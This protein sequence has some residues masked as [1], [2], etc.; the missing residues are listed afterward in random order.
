MHQLLNIVL[1]DGKRHRLHVVI[2]AGHVNVGDTLRIF[3]DLKRRL[4]Q[5]HGIDLL[6][7]IVIAKKRERAPLM[8]A[9]FLAS[10]YSMMRASSARGGIDYAAET[11][12]PPKGQAGL[13]FLEL[14]PDALRRLKEDFETDR[15]EAVA[16]WRANRRAKWAASSAK[17]PVV[18]ADESPC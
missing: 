12:E 5:R 13:T 16:A 8:V 10:T 6:G 1:A 2:E 3:E 11:P 18:F 15:Q 14:L 9:D 17:E 4:K 7:E